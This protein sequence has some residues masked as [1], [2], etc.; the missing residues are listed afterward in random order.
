MNGSH[1]NNN[2]IIH[3][4]GLPWNTTENEVEKFLQG[5]KVRQV[6]FTTNETGRA[7]G[8]CF[9]VLES[10]EDVDIAKNFHKTN[11]GSRTYSYIS[12]AKTG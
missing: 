10:Q 3:L 2:F 1:G 12:K 9:V 6:T 5:C 4:C 11:L 7:T 8:E